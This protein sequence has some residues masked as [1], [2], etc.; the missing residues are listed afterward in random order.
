MAFAT[1][2]HLKGI[3]SSP[4]ANLSD[5]LKRASFWACSD[6]IA[7]SDTGT[8]VTLF[9]HPANITIIAV[10]PEVETALTGT[11][12]LGPLL[13][14]DDGST[15]ALY[16]QW[17]GAIMDAGSY[18]LWLFKELTSAGSIKATLTATGSS[19]GS[20]KVWVCYQPN[21]NEDRIYTR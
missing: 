12:T 9:T 10:V 5:I 21:S 6:A 2:K 1:T 4:E 3:S 7:Y 18:P 20:V 13:T 8:A 14:V 15:T 17:T 19:A 16:G 11:I